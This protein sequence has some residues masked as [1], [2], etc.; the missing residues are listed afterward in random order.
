M[1]IA[2]AAQTVGAKRITDNVGESTANR[3]P[4]AAFVQAQE[5]QI[6]QGA[7]EARG[8]G[9][10]AW[11]LRDRRC[12]PPAVLKIIPTKP[13]VPF[14]ERA[15]LLTIA[16]VARFTMRGQPVPESD[17]LELAAAIV[18]FDV[19][20]AYRWA[21][22]GFRVR[23][24]ERD[25]RACLELTSADIGWLRRI[26]SAAHETVERLDARAGVRT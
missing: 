14:D 17:D 26:I 6:R 11:L 15:G 9:E 20:G 16:R 8:R 10:H 18:T 5:A 2:P 3:G 13:L 1:K 4:T 24:Y 23:G 19:P 25:R 22:A 21:A 7:A 12:A